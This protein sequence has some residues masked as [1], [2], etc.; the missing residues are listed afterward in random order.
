MLRLLCR[1]GAPR[2]ERNH[3]GGRGVIR[4]VKILL[5]HL[6]PL[7]RRGYLCQALLVNLI[8][9]EKLKG[10]FLLFV[11]NLY[12]LQEENGGLQHSQYIFKTTEGKST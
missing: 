4:G 9:G 11:G 2:E 6:G 10:R 12:L 1:S 8:F 3:D 5:Q 7:G